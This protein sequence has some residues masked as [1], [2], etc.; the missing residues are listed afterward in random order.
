M[1]IQPLKTEGV[2]TPP[3]T[4]AKA[5]KPVK[6]PAT[7]DAPPVA[8]REELLGALANEPAVRPE[9]IARG[10]D[11]A[12]DP[13]YPSDDLLAKLADVFVKDARRAK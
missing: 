1:N 9:E 5:A 2:T 8:K 3:K 12:A 6:E 7:D 13:N 10:K 11:L 4:A